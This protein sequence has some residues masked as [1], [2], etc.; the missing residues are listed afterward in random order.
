MEFL[1]SIDISIKG[2]SN[3]VHFASYFM[4]WRKE[5]I[6]NWIASDEYLA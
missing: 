4:T 2:V 5:N 1:F 6:K 3:K